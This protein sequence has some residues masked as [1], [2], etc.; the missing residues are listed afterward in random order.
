MLGER[1]R[2]HGGG[3]FADGQVKGE[4]FGSKGRFEKEERVVE[5]PSLTKVE[6]GVYLYYN[7]IHLKEDERM[8]LISV[9][10]NEAEREILE[11][12]ASIYGCGLSSMMKM[13]VFEKLEEEYDLKIVE[14]YERKKAKGEIFFRPID[15]LWKELGL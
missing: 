1:V 6:N 7:V 15:E 3:D 2:V 4:D 8:S 14:D 12:A 13:L 5:C 10:V 11:K 9:R